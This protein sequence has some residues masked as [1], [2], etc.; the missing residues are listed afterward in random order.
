MEFIAKKLPCI[1]NGKECNEY[2]YLEGTE[3][4]ENGKKCTLSERKTGQI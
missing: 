1:G 4:D 2:R 3:R